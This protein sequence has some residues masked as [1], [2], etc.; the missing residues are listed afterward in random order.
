[1]AHGGEGCMYIVMGNVWEMAPTTCIH[2]NTT[3]ENNN[4]IEH[5]L[6]GCNAICNG[7]LS[8]ASDSRGQM[9]AA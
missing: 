6:S 9:E 1:M 4:A 7:R 3:I 8:R 5:H 2:C